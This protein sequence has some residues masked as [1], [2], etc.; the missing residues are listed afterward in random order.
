MPGGSSSPIASALQGRPS[1][2][3]TP[4]PTG[5]SA[6]I[7]TSGDEVYQSFSGTHKTITKS[8]GAWEATYQG[9]ST[10]RGGT[11]KY[12]NAQGTLHYKGRITADSFFEEDEGVIRY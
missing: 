3:R 7:T 8:D 4:S 10:I 9:V 2:P 12:K 11:G 6:L 1:G 5:V